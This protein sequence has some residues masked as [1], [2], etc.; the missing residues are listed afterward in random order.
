MKTV[1][2]FQK[3]T[4]IHFTLNQEIVTVLMTPLNRIICRLI[5]V[6]FEA[7]QK[8]YWQKLETLVKRGY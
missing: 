2:F 5:I 6:S 4:D 7:P 8:K 1:I 3:Y